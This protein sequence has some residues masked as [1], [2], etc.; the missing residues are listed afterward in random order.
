MSVVEVGVPTGFVFEMVESRKGSSQQYQKYE[1][2]DGKV[3]L[4]YDRVR[5]EK[6]VHKLL[7]LMNWKI[8]LK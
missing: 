7:S 5:I 2:K 3:V 1:T 6:V 8:T 4:Y